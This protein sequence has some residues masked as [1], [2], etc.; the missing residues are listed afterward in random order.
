M[1]TVYLDHSTLCDAFRANAGDATVH[2]TYKTLFQ[3]VE[4]VA[5]EG[6]LC[7]SMF[8]IDELGAW[9]DIS[10]ANG[11]AQWL[12]S[13]NV[14]WTRTAARV[15]SEEDD[16][17]VAELAGVAELVEV[18]PFAGSLLG[19]FDG[20]SPSDIAEMLVDPTCTAVLQAFRAGEDSR[21]RRFMPE[22]H[23]VLVD[24]RAAAASSS[25]SEDEL[26]AQLEFQERVALRK[27]AWNA[28]HRLESLPGFRASGADLNSI[29]DPFVD[30]V[31][32]DASLLRTHTIQRSYMRGFEADTMAK[33]PHGTR[34]TRLLRGAGHDLQHALVVAAFCDVF[35]CDRVTAAWIAAGR[36]ALGFADAHWVG[37]DPV[38][39][40]E[41][42]MASNQGG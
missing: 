37:S 13:V 17:L 34:T 2:P 40:V 27:R 18:R 7:L 4:S 16:R 39:F 21:L 20:A 38:D 1:P 19:M 22:W 6:G 24:N 3:W 29:V 41:R 12:D 42:L 8:H 30:R 5:L 11:L 14:R 36:R 23:A 15:S 31:Q 35:T 28:F 32:A 25:V 26:R 9:A 10:A 33:K